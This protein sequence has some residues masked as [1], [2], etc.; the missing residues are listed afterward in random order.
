MRGSKGWRRAPAR[1]VRPSSITPDAAALVQTPAAPTF[2]GESCPGCA[3]FEVPMDAGDQFGMFE[4]SLPAPADMTNTTI[5]WRVMAVGFTG[6]SGG[7]APYVRDEQN[8]DQCFIW[9]NLSALSA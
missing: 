6:T 1:T 2:E 5:T 8:R 4:L 7:V 9:N 3:R